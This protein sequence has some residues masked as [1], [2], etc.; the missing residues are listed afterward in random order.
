MDKQ[1]TYYEILNV[2]SEASALGIVKAYRDIKEIYQPSALATYS[3]YS[4]EELAAM[5]ECIE[6]AYLVLSNSESRRIYDEQIKTTPAP[7]VKRKK[8]STSTKEK[9]KSTMPSIKSLT[10]PKHVHGKAL[11]KVRKSQGITLDHIADKT[12]IPKTYLKALEADDISAF[13][14]TFYLKSYLKQYA[15][16]IGLNPQQTWKAYQAHVK[17]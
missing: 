15:S 11:K 5:N 8:P 2:S 17:D 16:S 9:M 6:E 7:K 3:L 1:P 4:E 14:G 10:L 13:P 12:N